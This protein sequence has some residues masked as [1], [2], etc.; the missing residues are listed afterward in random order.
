M[1]IA[2]VTEGRGDKKIYKSWIPLVNPDIT[3]VDHIIDIF[4]DNFA[5]VSAFGYPSYFDVILGVIDDVNSH[6]SIDRVVI[7]VDSEEFTLQQKQAEMSTFLACISCSTPILVVYQHFCIETWALGNRRACPANP[8][9]EPLSTFKRFF[10]V[11][12][13]DPE[14][15]TPYPPLGNN[16]AQ[17]A[18]TYLKAMLHARSPHTTY[19]KSRPKPLLHHTYFRQILRR[20]QA[21][22]HI[23]SFAF[24]LDAFV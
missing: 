13:S 7:G 19:I 16:R 15:L 14:L 23:A 9:H 17:F 4:T 11:R 6:G 1:N 5:I 3:Y 21:T 22:T 12:T 10:D 2:V 24:F 20:H 18:E 8:S